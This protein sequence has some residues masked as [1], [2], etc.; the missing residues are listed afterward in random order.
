[1][2]ASIRNR[3]G[4]RRGQL[5]SPGIIMSSDSSATAIGTLSVVAP[6][7]TLTSSSA[8]CSLEELSTSRAACAVAVAAG[9]GVSDGGLGSAAATGMMV[10]A[11]VFFSTTWPAQRCRTR[12]GLSVAWT[13]FVRSGRVDVGSR[14]SYPAAD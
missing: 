8:G 5:S 12:A 1:M 10:R 11:T 14:P 6:G 7:A 3:A 4:L 13:A 2:I 9:G